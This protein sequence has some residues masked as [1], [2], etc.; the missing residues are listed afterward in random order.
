MRKICSR[1]C[2]VYRI[3]GTRGIYSGDGLLGNRGFV[4]YFR[5]ISHANYVPGPF[6]VNYCFG[7]HDVH[8]WSCKISHL[9][10]LVSPP[11]ILTARQTA[12]IK[13]N[14]LRLLYVREV[15]LETQSGNRQGWM[16]ECCLMILLRMGVSVRFRAVMQL[17]FH[18]PTADEIRGLPEVTAS[19]L[20]PTVCWF[21]GH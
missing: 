8:Y 18:V 12:F 3:D 20:E 21:L 17:K 6:W 11:Q 4:V 2:T 1:G 5:V 15:T 9:L 7:A 10:H 14:D 13:C 19:R 16:C